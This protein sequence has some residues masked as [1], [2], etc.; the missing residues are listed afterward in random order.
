M[1]GIQIE[2]GFM[3]PGIR[4]RTVLVKYKKIKKGNIW[5]Q[6]FV[7]HKGTRSQPRRT[8]NFRAVPNSPLNR[9][10]LHPSPQTKY[11]TV[12]TIHSQPQ[13]LIK[14]SEN[15]VDQPWWLSS[16]MGQYHS[17][18][19]HFPCERWFES[20]HGRRLVGSHKNLRARMRVYIFP[21]KQ[22]PVIVMCKN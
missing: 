6:V 22:E 11:I 3:V 8:L 19:W 2:F 20:R 5:L 7:R 4:S 16:L 18:Y 21:D 12:V 15:L 13:Q 1:C 9:V 17:V 14:Y 10:W